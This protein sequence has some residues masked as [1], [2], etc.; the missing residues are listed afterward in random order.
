MIY[1]NGNKAE[2]ENELDSLRQQK[3]SNSSKNSERKNDWL[4]P[5][6][7]FKVLLLS[8]RTNTDKSIRLQPTSKSVIC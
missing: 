5:L 3:L 2:L 8:C 7:S 1:Q 4:L 6:E